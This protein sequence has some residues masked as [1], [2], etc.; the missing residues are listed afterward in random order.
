MGGHGVSEGHRVALTRRHGAVGREYK[1]TCTGTKW[2]CNGVCKGH[3]GHAVGYE[4]VC[5]RMQGGME[6]VCKGMQKWHK[7]AHDWHKGHP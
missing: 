5:N 2:G 4:G 1:R 3:G 7:E 6:G